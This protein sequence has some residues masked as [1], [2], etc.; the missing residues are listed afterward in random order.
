MG[1]VRTDRFTYAVRPHELNILLGAFADDLPWHYKI[2][3]S[4]GQPGWDSQSYIRRVIET[5]KTYSKGVF[6]VSSADFQPQFRQLAGTA[7]KFTIHSQLH[8]L[9]IKGTGYR[10]C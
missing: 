9:R 1:G 3:Y 10:Q 4:D 5:R 2:R 8:P 6:S 7:S